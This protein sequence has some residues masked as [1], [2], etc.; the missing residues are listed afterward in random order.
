MVYLTLGE[1]YSG[2]Y[3]SQVIDVCIHL[4]NEFDKDIKLV[5]IISLRNFFQE[6]RKIK[7]EIEHAVIL[8]MMPQFLG[9]LLNLPLLLLFF[10]FSKRYSVICRNVKATNLCLII[11]KIGLLSKVCYDGRGAIKAEREE[12]LDNNGLKYHEFELNAVQKS[13][14]RIAVSNQLVEYWKQ[15]F[16][17]TGSAHLV[18]PC[19]L[20][21]SF[22]S[23]L[24]NE[25]KNIKVRKKLGFNKKD[26]VLVYAGSLAGWQ[27]F[28]LIKDFLNYVLQKN[29]NVKVLLMSKRDENVNRILN[30][31]PK[32]VVCT[33]VNHRE[34]PDYL[35]ACDYGLLLREDSVTNRVA[36]PT[37]FAEYLS[38]GLSV[39]ISNTVVDYAELVEKENL[40]I[41]VDN[42]NLKKIIIDK[43]SYKEKINRAN[44]SKKYFSKKSSLNIGKYKE[45]L[46]AL[47]SDL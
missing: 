22:T 18:I 36:A 9:W 19:T 14:F 32:D 24:L 41:V 42:Y 1:G 4:R 35:A 6:R 45:L 25:E 27:S 5:S 12:Y 21:L 2:V 38:A 37:K 28:N 33:W 10:L 29:S 13:D 11:K 3:K 16:N 46:R 40:G 39:I 7:K 15:E 17:Y 34:V 44:F 23:S 30:M 26:I 20:G 47:E 31:F 8:P 43:V